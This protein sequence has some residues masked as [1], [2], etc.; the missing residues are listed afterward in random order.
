MARRVPTVL[1]SEQ[2]ECGLACL[3]AIAAFHGSDV[4]LAGLRLRHAGSSRGATLAQVMRVA[5]DLGMTTRALRMEPGELASLRLPATL[6]WD[7]CH[8][9]VLESV[10]ARRCRIMDPARGRCDISLADLSRHFTGIA[11]ELIPG[12]APSDIPRAPRP[13]IT[14]WLRATPGLGAALGHALLLS[15][16][17]QLLALLAPLASQW[18]LDRAIPGADLPLLQLIAIASALLA[19]MHLLFSAAR[20]WLNVRL[21]ADLRGAWTQHLFTRLT[22]L[23]LPFFQR[24]GMGDILSRFDSLR[25]V[26]DLVTRTTPE[27]LLDGLM[28]S[29]TLALMFLYSPRLTAI[30]ALA[31]S[32]YAL[33]RLACY[34]MQV[35]RTR[36]VLRASAGER[37]VLVETLRCAVTWK[38]RAGEAQRRDRYQ[39][40]LSRELAAEAGLG[41]FTAAVGL[42]R[43]GL[44]AAERIAV[45]WLGSAAVI[46]GQFT[47]GMLVAFLAYKNLFSSRIA[48]LVDR[49]FE[50][51]GM[52]LHL[53]R[54]GDIIAQPAEKLGFSG[55]TASGPPEA[56]LLQLQDIGFRFGEG[57]PW[58]FRHLDV[59]LEAGRWLALHAPSG[60][61]KTTLSSIACGL[62]RP[63]EGRVLYRGRDICHGLQGYRRQIGVV[64]QGDELL[65]GTVAE[66]I[67]FFSPRP[68]R[69]R[70]ER[71]ARAA[72]I[73]A[74]ICRWPLGY[75]TR[76]G[77]LAHGLSAGQVQRLLIARALYN[78][79]RLLL[80]DEAFSH[81]DADSEQRIILALR[82]M[83]LACLFIS[84]RARCRRLADTVL[85]LQ[86]PAGRAD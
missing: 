29:T 26:Q 51:R 32:V 76:I 19:L 13:S 47:V 37:S 75:F 30:S 9:V 23:P 82:D 16:C 73:H 85:P 83:G 67:C 14:Q 21:A 63:Q 60:A 15:G 74:A 54:L 18:I 35:R 72:G 49:A 57:E 31:W 4:Q 20:A 45:L 80:L 78:S 59:S 81:L 66:N 36:E 12:P 79:P 25:P 41:T 56:P 43:Q 53:Q 55:W 33:A 22:A 46:A 86:P 61:G 50:L 17:L 28:A 34:P 48:A 8:F 64:L 24:R 40:V 69:A 71:A 27:I 3:A 65:A 52:E 1:Q 68:E 44:D 2:G 39:G 77:D 11:L 84:H 7:L 38:L 58:L 5:G 10:S 70:I 42:L 62:L 6:H